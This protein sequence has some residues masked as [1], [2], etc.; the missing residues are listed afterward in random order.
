L[1][2]SSNASGKDYKRIGFA[3]GIKLEG[4]YAR[5]DYKPSQFTDRAVYPNGMWTLTFREDGSFVDNG[6]VRPLYATPLDTKPLSDDAHKAL[7]QP[8]KGKY[9]L[10]NNT[11][12]LTY[13]D[14]RVVR[15]G[16]WILPGDAGKTSPPLLYINEAP[17]TKR[18]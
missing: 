15:L 16:F 1:L 8:G 2:G 17:L 5:E 11:L 4:T 12:Y 18:D 9:R 7:T 3:T 13:D 6:Q 10:A 14:G